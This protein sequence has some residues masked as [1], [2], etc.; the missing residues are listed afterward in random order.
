[1]IRFAAALIAAAAWTSALAADFVPSAP[2]P[3]EF[4]VR[5]RNGDA[6]TAPQLRAR[7]TVL[8]FWASWCLP[9]RD[10]LPA[11]QSLQSDLAGD[12]VR[13]VAVSVDRLG[14]DAIDRTTVKLDVR[15]LELYHDRDREA[16]AA[17]GVEALP[18][19]IL[20]D[21]EGREVARM[22]GQGEW[23]NPDVRRDLLRFRDAP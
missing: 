7:L 8:H 17:L 16:T 23:G 11:L 10:E 22:R 3:I 18:T 9:C 21:A 12:G 20:V 14:W 1:M 4:V 2:R 13:V 19:T 15:G 5:D 6:R